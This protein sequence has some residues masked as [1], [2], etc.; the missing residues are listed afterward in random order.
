M[1]NWYADAGIVDAQAALAGAVARAPAVP[2]AGAWDLG[3]ESSNCTVPPSTSP[4]PRW[5]DWM[6]SVLRATD[7]GRPITVGNQRRTSRTTG[8]SA[9]PRR[10]VVRLR[11]HSTPSGLRRLAR[12][13]SIPIWCPSRRD[14]RL[15]EWRCFCALRG[16]RSDDGA[17]RRR[18]GRHPGDRTDAAVYTAATVDAL[19]RAGSIGALL[20]VLR[21]LRPR[22]VVRAALRPVCTSA[23]S[24]CG[25]HDGTPKPAVAELHDLRSRPCVTGN[26]DRPWID[27]TPDELPP[28]GA[29]SLGGST[30]A[31]APDRPEAEPWPER[32]VCRPAL[33]YGAGADGALWCP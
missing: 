5:L 7:P 4:A 20:V 6:T 19:R 23:P 17:A 28:T 30:T 2:R 1:R 21:R 25:T 29:A 32:L 13:R 9:R 27:I 14:H 31:T 3:N 12:G 11:A 15:A 33:F 26:M 8:G 16:A 24:G 10:L 22:A 18:A